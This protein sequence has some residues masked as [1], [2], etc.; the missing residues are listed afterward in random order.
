MVLEGVLIGLGWLP[1]E[2]FYNIRI[3]LWKWYV[4]YSGI[5]LDRVVWRFR[6]A[7]QFNDQVNPPAKGLAINFD[8]S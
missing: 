8:R 3:G 6:V 4:E 5:F 1:L 7:V 2:V